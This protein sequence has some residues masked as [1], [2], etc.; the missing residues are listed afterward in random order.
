MS[1][2]NSDKSHRNQWYRSKALSAAVLFS[3]SV[4]IRDKDLRHGKCLIRVW[5][6]YRRQLIVYL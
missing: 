6:T 2:R 5:L 1:H 4:V 3:L